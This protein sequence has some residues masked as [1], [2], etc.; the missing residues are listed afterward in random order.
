MISLFQRN[1]IALRNAL[2]LPRKEP[3]VAEAFRLAAII[4]GSIKTTNPATLFQ[5]G[6]TA[7]KFG[8]P[9]PEAAN[10]IST[11]KGTRYIR[12]NDRYYGG[13]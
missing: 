12:K 3:D 9:A 1:R 5:T 11:A 8:T 4:A 13:S 2:R 10:T 6:T 7:V